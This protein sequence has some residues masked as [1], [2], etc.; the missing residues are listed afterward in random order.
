MV[1]VVVMVLTLKKKKMVMMQT[2]TKFQM[3][4]KNLKLWVKLSS[5]FKKM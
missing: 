2:L 5:T 3:T 4:E 1:E